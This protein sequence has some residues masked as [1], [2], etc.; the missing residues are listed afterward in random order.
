M[1]TQDIMDL[2]K[3][4]NPFGNSATSIEGLTAFRGASL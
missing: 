1:L 4:G 2:L 3:A